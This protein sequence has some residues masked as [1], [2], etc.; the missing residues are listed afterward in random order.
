MLN[1][2]QVEAAFVEVIVA[3]EL[4]PYLQAG[5]LLLARKASV[6]D[7][8]NLVLTFHVGMPAPVRRV[9]VDILLEC[10]GPEG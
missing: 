6:D 2:E 10:P 9:T 8:D 4:R 3:A 1:F 7:D 5:G